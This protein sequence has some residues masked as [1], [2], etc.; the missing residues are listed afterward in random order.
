MGITTTP[1]NVSNTCVSS[2]L[3][4]SSGEEA[5]TPVLNAA[6]KETNVDAEKKANEIVT[7]MLGAV[8]S[9][10]RAA[11]EGGKEGFSQAIRSRTESLVKNLKQLQ[12]SKNNNNNNSNNNK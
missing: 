1:S 7:S 3:E 6:W 4:S 12:T 9:L 5:T 8:S 11:N 10:G 2:F